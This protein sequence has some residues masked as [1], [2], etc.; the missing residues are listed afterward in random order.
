[1][2]SPR[3]QLVILAEAPDAFVELFG[4]SMVERLLR[5][6]QRIGFREAIV[7]STTPAE[8]AAHLAA[9]SW[10][11]TQISLTF[12]Q[13]EPGPVSMI[14]VAGKERA[15]VVSAGFYYDARLLKT[16]AGK[17]TTTVLV[18][19]RRPA[20]TIRLWQK[21]R[22]DFSGAALVI[23]DPA[24]E[25]KQCDAADEPT[26]VTA[27]RKHV[28]PVFF[29]A[30]SPELIPL[31]EK[32]PRD[33]AQNGVLDF[34]GFLDSPIEDWIVRR[35]CRT[36]VRPNQVTFVTTL[37]GLAVTALFAT[38]RLWWGVA[39]AYAIE[40]LDG[41]DGK[42][43]RTKVETTTAGQWE[44]EVDYTIELSWWTALA[45]HFRTSGLASAYWLLALY[46]V[47]DLID[48][49]AKRAVKLKVGRNLDD[50][51][52]FDRFVRCIGAR[53]NINIW[54]L[55]AALALGDPGNGFVL[56]CWWGAAG[57]VVHVVRAIRIRM[58][59]SE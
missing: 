58:T 49:V 55:I 56:F 28:R 59:K 6:A 22:L 36:S 44:H 39:L 30:P 19:S 16:L 20:E 45:F 15:L 57:A 18:D 54:I 33:V 51:S 10:A 47:S 48:R 1:M 23:P 2:E 41:V 40:V 46:V 7:L 9:P 11:R 35:L 13:R 17:T 32:F 24:W 5:Q 3:P 21:E 31:A 34:P 25:P 14:Q 52:N 12:H 4:V 29:P 26:Y 38:G 37:I 27:L 42:L 8:M 43:A 53:R 50:V